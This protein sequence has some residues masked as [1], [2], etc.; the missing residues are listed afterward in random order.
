MRATCQFSPDGHDCLNIATRRAMVPGVANTVPTCDECAPNWGPR[1]VITSVSGVA[2]PVRRLR[3]LR[4][5][6]AVA[7][8]CGP[9]SLL[10]RESLARLVA[11]AAPFGA[12]ARDRFFAALRQRSDNLYPVEYP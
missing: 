11:L 3:L 6:R 1:V 7:N 8:G 9:L 10:S 12:D 2:L 4:Q 5:V